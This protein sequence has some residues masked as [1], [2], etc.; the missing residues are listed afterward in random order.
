MHRSE[1]AGELMKG[2]F[3]DDDAEGLQIDGPPDTDG[4]ET[5]AAI[6]AGLPADRLQALAGELEATHHQLA[7]RLASRHAEPA[8]APT[9][10][11]DVPDVRQHDN[12]SCGAAA[13]MSVG[14]FFGVG[15][16]TLEEWKQALGTNEKTS[17]L[18]SAIVDYLR[19]LGLDVEPR[20]LMTVAD[21]RQC[22]REGA[23]VICPIQEYGVPSKQASFDYGHYV[24]VIGIALG[25]VF[26]QDP[27]I[28]NV[29]GRPGGS[30]GT[31]ENKTDDQGADQ[32][33]GRMM[34]A[35]PEW[36]KVWHD[37]D[38]RGRRYIRYGIVVRGKAVD[39]G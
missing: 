13:A 28:D 24:T 32:T 29:L 8:T 30:V 21:L 25:Q 2:R 14:R 5:L 11:L 3:V 9:E 37:K 6:L 38:A 33:P 36:R 16:D 7:S 23:P 19:N 1:P 39:R 20:Q 27:L 17:T 15:P 22:W 10:L 26:V 12:Y 4:T 35:V 31:A 18:P 34:I